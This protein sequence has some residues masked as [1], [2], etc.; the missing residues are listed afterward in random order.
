[1]DVDDGAQAQIVSS[2]LLHALQV[3]TT[4]LAVHHVPVK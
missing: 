4:S 3:M 2:A 1:M